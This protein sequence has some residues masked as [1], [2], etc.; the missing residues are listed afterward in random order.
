MK[1]LQN[2]GNLY[3]VVELILQ[4]GACGDLMSGWSKAL[5]TSLEKNNFKELSDAIRPG[6]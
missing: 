3:G 4:N 2:E 1:N 5:L 6:K